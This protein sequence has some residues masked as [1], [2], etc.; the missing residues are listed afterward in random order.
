MQTDG[1]FVVYN[2]GT[3][4]WNSMTSGS[5]GAYLQLQDDSNLVIYQGGTALWDGSS[6]KLVGGGGVGT[7]GERILDEAAKGSRLSL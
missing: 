3:A 5:S 6:G 7:T 4:V 1:N 2:G